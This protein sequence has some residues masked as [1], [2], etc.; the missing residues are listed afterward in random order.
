MGFENVLDYY[1]LLDVKCNASTATIEAG[2]RRMSMKFHPDKDGN[3]RIFAKLTEARDTL[4]DH[5]AAPR[6]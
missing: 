4:V 3:S 1:E 5:S 6:L 2:Y